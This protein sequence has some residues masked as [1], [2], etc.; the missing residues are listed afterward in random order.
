MPSSSALLALV[1]LAK[2]ALTA[3]AAP[4]RS[5]TTTTSSAEPANRPATRPASGPDRYSQVPA[6]VPTGGPMMPPSTKLAPA[7]S[8]RAPMARAV[9]GAM[10]LA[11][12]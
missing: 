11:S 4:G 9:E 3:E 2:Q 1:Q 6:P 7:P 10:A 8:S 5:P 12:T